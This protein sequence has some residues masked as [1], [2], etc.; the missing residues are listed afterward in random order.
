VLGEEANEVVKIKATQKNKK[1][2]KE[3]KERKKQMVQKDR[4]RNKIAN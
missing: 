2:K 3:K 4:R 1:S